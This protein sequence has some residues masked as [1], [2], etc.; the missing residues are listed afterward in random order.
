M[1]RTRIVGGVYTK[2]TGGDYKM[3]TE[4]DTIISAA[5]KNDFANAEKVI[6]GTDPERCELR[7]ETQGNKNYQTFTDFRHYLVLLR[8]YNTQRINFHFE[9]KYWKMQANI[10]F[11]EY[12]TENIILLYFPKEEKSLIKFYKSEKKSSFY[13]DQYLYQIII[14]D[15]YEIN[16]FSKKD[17]DTI[18]DYLNGKNDVF[19]NNSI[20]I[21]EKSYSYKDIYNNLDEKKGNLI[22]NN[23]YGDLNKEEQFIFS[24]PLIMWSKKY[25]YGAIFMYNWIMGG[26]NI[27]V[28]DN[29]F[30]FLDK[31]EKLSKKE[32]EFINFINKSKRKRIIGKKIDYEFCLYP[33]VDLREY[34]KNK[35]SKNE[36]IPPLYINREIEINE[37]MLNFSRLNASVDYFENINDPHI[38][39]FGTFSYAFIFEGVYNKD[40]QE[41]FI[42]KILQYI[43]DR[44][45]FEGMQPLG[46][47]SEDIFNYK[48]NIAKID[49]N[50]MSSSISLYNSTFRSFRKK[51]ELG[52]DFSIIG[53]RDYK[54]IAIEKIKIYHNSIEYE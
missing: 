46:V 16:C 51:T 42:E 40:T 26:G 6:I 3:Y 29:M 41:V 18:F 25:E 24:L 14:N 48:G 30:S 45:D 33:L 2:I 8:L 20:I 37:K 19:L 5:G 1:S 11:F 9:E 35:I 47:W 7:K 53:H 27:K 39:A 32:S 38:A 13:K 43:N 21:G 31:W 36:S 44:F 12:Q 50:P 52:K 49:L 17:R 15:I 23:K 34:L 54:K 10:L 22:K 4:G 28:D